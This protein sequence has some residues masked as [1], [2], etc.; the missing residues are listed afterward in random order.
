M[1]IL[2]EPVMNFEIEKSGFFSHFHLWTVCFRATSLG[3]H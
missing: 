2:L 1:K 3:K